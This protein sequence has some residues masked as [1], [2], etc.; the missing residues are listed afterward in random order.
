[1]SD[2]QARDL[3]RRARQGDV[4]AAVRLIAERR[5]AGTLTR[6]RVW[7]AAA[8]GD[9]AARRVEGVPYD[10]A[11]EPQAMRWVSWTA[12]QGP[13]VTARMAAAALEVAWRETSFCCFVPAARGFVLEARALLAAWLEDAAREGL[14]GRLRAAARPP[15]DAGG[16]PCIEVARSALLAVGAPRP[17]VC[18]EALTRAVRLAGEATSE[19]QVRVGIRDAVVPW[20]LGL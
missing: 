14:T 9:E 5:R 15:A 4:D 12:S 3:A 11:C 13:E 20:A 6:E 8:L 16:H 2:A 7:I 18:V 10:E 19:R 1:M 17:Y